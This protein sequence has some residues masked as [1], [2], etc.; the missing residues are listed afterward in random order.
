MNA[1]SGTDFT[2]NTYLLRLTGRRLLRTKILLCLLSSSQRNEANSTS[3][4]AEHDLGIGISDAWDLDTTACIGLRRI[5]LYAQTP[6]G[7][8]HS[9]APLRSRSSNAVFAYDHEWQAEI[10]LPSSTQAAQVEGAVPP[11]HEQDCLVAP[12]ATIHLHFCRLR[13]VTV[14]IHIPQCTLD[15]ALDSPRSWMR[16][17]KIVLHPKRRAAPAFLRFMWHHGQEVAP[18]GEPPRFSMYSSLC[19]LVGALVGRRDCW[20]QKKAWLGSQVRHGMEFRS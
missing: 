11:P 8:T 13:S 7:A 2:C 15:Q 14:F 1:C 9:P 19:C 17:A 4:P 12:D 3:F 20:K 5:R 16:D 6:S 10:L 18:I